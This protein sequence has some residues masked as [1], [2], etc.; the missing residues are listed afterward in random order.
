[1][2]G[3]R[4]SSRTA[5][6]AGS[7]PGEGCAEYR[8]GP[9]LKPS[10]L[11]CGEGV[12]SLRRLLAPKPGVAEKGPRTKGENVEKSPPLESAFSGGAGVSPFPAVSE[13]AHP[14]PPAV[15]RLSRRPSGEA[16]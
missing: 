1:M 12:P 10:P 14:A 5:A 4:G 9:S 15:L 11:E 2:R 13:V 8:G 7:C 3:R 16:P 6:T